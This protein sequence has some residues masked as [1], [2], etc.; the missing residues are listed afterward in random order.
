MRPPVPAS[1]C[2]ASIAAPA[3]IR[4]R[5]T[6]SVHDTGMEFP[7]AWCETLDLHGCCE[8][9]AIVVAVKAFGNPLVSHSCRQYPPFPIGCRCNGTQL[10]VRFLWM[11][12]LV[13]FTL[14]ERNNGTCR[15]ITTR[16]S[17]RDTA[18]SP[19]KKGGDSNP[20][21]PH[22]AHLDS[23]HAVKAVDF[24][25]LHNTELKSGS[26]PCAVKLPGAA[27]HRARSQ[28]P[29][30]AGTLLSQMRQ[31]L[32]SGL[33]NPQ[34]IRS[35]AAH[36][37]AVRQITAVEGAAA[38]HKNHV[39]GSLGSGLAVNGQPRADKAKASGLRGPGNA[40][41]LQSLLSRTIA[42]TSKA[43]NSRALHRPTSATKTGGDRRNTNTITDPSGKGC[44][45][46]A[47]SQG[48][49]TVPPP[50]LKRSGAAHRIAQR[51]QD[52]EPS[53]LA[54]HSDAAHAEMPE[55][56]GAGNTL[57]KQHPG[58]VFFHVMHMR[59]TDFQSIV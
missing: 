51:G 54:T 6:Q 16:V 8:H 30:D 23:G 53:V 40:G 59:S 55:A 7:P 35:E 5:P 17:C 29:S 47:L 33:S 24:G 52:A 43:S 41:R 44:E 45:M 28:Q 22:L 2:G 15:R 26:S 13:S 25:S 14:C 4:S 42:A 56:S 36:T 48:L 57:T 50:G 31:K 58:A 10:C 1:R 18:I 11:F 46:P 37:P 38:T 34:H 49:H 20:S 3:V 19:G 12:F 21:P 9:V 32:L 39:T 27:L